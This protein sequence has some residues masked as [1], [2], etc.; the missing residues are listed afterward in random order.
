MPRINN[1]TGKPAHAFC[2]EGS[3][4]QVTETALVGAQGPM[5]RHPCGNAPDFARHGAYAAQA[6]FPCRHDGWRRDD[7]GTEPRSVLV[8]EHDRDHAHGDSRVCR[9][10]GVV[11][12]AAVKIV[13]LEKDRVAFGLERAKVMLFVRVVRMTKVVKDGD[14]F[15]DARR[16]LFTEGGY[17]RGHHGDASCQVLS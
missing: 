14:G 1:F 6:L 4:P 17:T 12:Q 8:G 15:D 9:V 10:G 7:L 11:V 13:D 5:Y 3:A 16:G 2:R